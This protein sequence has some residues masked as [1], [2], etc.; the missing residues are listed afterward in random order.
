MFINVGNI[1]SRITMATRIFGELEKICRLVST[2]G[3]RSV[4]VR[5]RQ[6]RAR[7][8]RSRGAFSPMH[9]T[10]FQCISQ[11]SYACVCICYSECDEGRTRALHIARPK[12]CPSSRL[13]LVAILVTSFTNSTKFSHRE[14]LSNRPAI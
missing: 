14:M 2:K 3:I 13:S 9:S 1:E 7:R 10:H 4:C 6:K 12:R 8:D 11:G 5:A